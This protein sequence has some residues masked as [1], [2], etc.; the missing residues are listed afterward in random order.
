MTTDQVRT[1]SKNNNDSLIIK[2]YC[3]PTF[4]ISCQVMKAINEKK[5]LNGNMLLADGLSIGVQRGG[6]GFHDLEGAIR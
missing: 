3:N 6:L 4:V 1:F 2:F 5:Q